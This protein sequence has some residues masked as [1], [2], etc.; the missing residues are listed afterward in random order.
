M[1]TYLISI[2][3]HI[4]RSQRTDR[5]IYQTAH[6]QDENQETSQLAHPSAS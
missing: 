1:N 3:P 2:F 5:T 6:R 4:Y